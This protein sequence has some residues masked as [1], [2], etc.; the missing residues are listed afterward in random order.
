MKGINYEV[1]IVAARSKAWVWG[2]SFAGIAVSNSAGG[3][4][5]CVLGVMCVV[6]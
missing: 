5:V 4:D 6:R 2:R 1:P 3:L